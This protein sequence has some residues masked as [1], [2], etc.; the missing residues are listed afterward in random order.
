MQGYYNKSVGMNAGKIEAYTHKTEIYIGDHFI[1]GL[2]S[3]NEAARQRFNSVVCHEIFHCLT[4]NNPQ[5]KEDM[6]SIINFKVAD[7]DFGM[8][9]AVREVYYS[10]PDVDH[11]N[12]YIALTINGEKKDCFMVLATSKA[13]EKEGDLFTNNL[14]IIFV[15]VDDTN[16]YYALG[17]DVNTEEFLSLVGRNTRYMID[18]EECMADNFGYAIVYGAAGI[19][20]EAYPPPEI[21]DS[22]IAYLK[23]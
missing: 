13:F 3:D 6:Y 2:S 14:N 16:T 15:P 7:D 5:F 22:I 9:P 18:P 1:E 20:G 8:G 10:N 12:S 4:R 11:H 21:I 23:K 19:E 17:A